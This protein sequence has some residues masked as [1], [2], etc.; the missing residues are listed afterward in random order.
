MFCLL[1][2]LKQ[3]ISF[4]FILS[5]MYL[6]KVHIFYQYNYITQLIY[7]LKQY[8]C[9]SHSFLIYTGTSLIYQQPTW[10]TCLGLIPKVIIQRRVSQ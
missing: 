10:I 3:R 4:N 6:G 2:Y 1:N 8:I 7:K 5:L 9:K